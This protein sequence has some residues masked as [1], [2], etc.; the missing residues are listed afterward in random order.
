MFVVF[1]KIRLEK[2]YIIYSLLYIFVY[3]YIYIIFSWIRLDLLIFLIFCV[4]I[5]LNF[6]SLDF[7]I[8]VSVIVG[9]GDI[10]FIVI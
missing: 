6:M 5:G 8:V 1:E 9:V 2:V 10:F 4:I 7:V 3:V